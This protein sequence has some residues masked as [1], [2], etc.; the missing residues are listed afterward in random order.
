[1]HGYRGYI[2]MIIY[3]NVLLKLFIF[4]IVWTTYIAI[5]I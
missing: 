1:M 4:L 5:N 3:I 2:I